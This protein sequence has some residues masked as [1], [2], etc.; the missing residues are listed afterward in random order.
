MT[1]EEEVT[2]HKT[3]MEPVTKGELEPIIN[4]SVSRSVFASRGLK[5]LLKLLVGKNIISYEEITAAQDTINQENKVYYDIVN[6]CP[7]KMPIKT[8][9][10]SICKVCVIECPFDEAK[11]SG[12]IKN[13]LLLEDS[14]H[15]ARANHGY[16]EEHTIYKEFRKNAQ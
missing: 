11:K 6:K 7:H 15:G 1:N 10:N 16:I 8:D 5:I 2:L 13:A 12:V 14:M 3:L 4:S 9:T